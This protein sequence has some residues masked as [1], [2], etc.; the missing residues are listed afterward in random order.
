MDVPLLLMILGYIGMEMRH[1]HVILTFSC[2]SI[3]WSYNQYLWQWMIFDISLVLYHIRFLESLIELIGWFVWSQDCWETFYVLRY[4]LEFSVSLC[5]KT[6][7]SRV[8]N[9]QIHSTHTRACTPTQTASWH[10]YNISGTKAIWT[11]GWKYLL[12]HR[13]SV[14]IKG[15]WEIGL[16]LPQWIP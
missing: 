11:A 15:R 6:Q 9:P 4:S 12:G 3:L 8:P 16:V 14:Y 5:A 10:G 1:I 2:E 7:A 13:I